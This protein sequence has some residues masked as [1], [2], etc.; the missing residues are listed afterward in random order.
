M[1][2]S[3]VGNG[4]WWE[5]S[6][7]WGKE[8]CLTLT[9]PLALLL[10]YREMGK[11]WGS[12]SAGRRSACCSHDATRPVER[13]EGIHASNARLS[14][15]GVGVLQGPTVFVHSSVLQ[16]AVV[17]FLKSLLCVLVRTLQMLS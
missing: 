4:G 11:V 13:A 17:N 7:G 16:Q 8:P 15:S 1:L 3:W 2:L 10:N 12:P 6:R 9:P 5:G 14:L